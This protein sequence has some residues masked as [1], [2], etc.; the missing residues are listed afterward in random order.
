MLLTQLGELQG[1]FF[2][3]FS[4]CKG[5]LVCTKEFSQLRS[6]IGTWSAVISESGQQVLWNLGHLEK[7]K[8]LCR[9][10]KGSVH[11]SPGTILG[12]WWGCLLRLLLCLNLITCNILENAEIML[13]SLGLFPFVFL[14]RWGFFS[15]GLSYFHDVFP[16]VFISTSTVSFILIFFFYLC[17]IMWF[18]YTTWKLTLWLF[19]S[20][21]FVAVLLVQYP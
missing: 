11:Y 6:P 10:E 9:G 13:G 4:K 5:G 20:L 12:C 2:F 21:S 16:F 17:F 1:F 7:K 18:D 15:L 3:F 14:S 8:K 19:E